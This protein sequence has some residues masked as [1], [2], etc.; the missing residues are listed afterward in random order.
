MRPS[1]GAADDPLVELTSRT[2]EEV[3]G[4]PAMVTP[5]RRPM[6]YRSDKASGPPPQAAH[7]LCL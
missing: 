2:G 4:K 7:L 3:Y 1:K 6:S 5:I